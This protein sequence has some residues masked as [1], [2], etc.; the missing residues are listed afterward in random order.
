MPRILLVQGANLTYL[1]KREP[2]IYGTTTAAELNAQLERHAKDNSYELE[3]FYT[4]VEGEAIN[5]IYEAASN[6]VDGLVMNPAGF[7]HAGYA[8][9]DCVKGCGLPYVE[10]HISNIAK[11]NIHSVLA[12][13]SEGVV[14]GFGLHGYILGLEGM[15]HILEARRRR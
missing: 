5:R 2:E 11:R 14:Y 10:V 13:V 7:T 1:G 12:D 15:R 8:L 6:S 4:N 9:R 3:I